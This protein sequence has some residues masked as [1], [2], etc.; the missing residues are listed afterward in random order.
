M[1]FLLLSLGLIIF[2][3]LKWFQKYFIQFILVI[4][5]IGIFIIYLMDVALLVIWD[6]DGSYH[7]L[8]VRLY[9]ISANFDFYCNS[10]VV[11][12]KNYALK[13]YYKE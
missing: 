10:L 2:H 13:W 1:W 11:Y 8:Q 4:W 6:W 3:T 12:M 7:R 9:R 5:T